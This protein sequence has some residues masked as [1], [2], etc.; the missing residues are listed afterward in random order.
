[1]AQRA[2]AV[3]AFAAALLAALMC[4]LPAT[5][6]TSL[7]SV[8]AT[9]SQAR[10]VP[11]VRGRVVVIGV[12]GLRWS[13]ISATTTPTLW[14]MTTIGS[15]AALSAKTVA[16]NT[17]PIDGWL[18]VSAGQRA[19][20]SHG[21]C[22]LPPAPKTDGARADVPGFAEMREDNTKSKYAAKLGL[23]GDA[24]H[25]A[26]GCTMAV[27]PGATFGAMDGTGLVDS[28]APSIDQVAT[29]G[30][31][32]C[33]LTMVDVDD[34]FR[35]YIDAGVD[36]NGHQV[37]VSNQKRAAA[38]ALADQ[39]IF[40][41]ISRL[42]VGTTVLLAG[43]ADTGSAAHLHVAIATGPTYGSRYL[44]A[45]S[46]HTN[47]LVALT[48]VT[49]TALHV[50]GLSKP[51]DAVGSPWHEGSAKPSTAQAVRHL[52]QEDVAARASS[53]LST[54]YFTALGIAQIGLYVAAWLVLRNPGSPRD[55]R[56][57]RK[58]AAV[59]TFALAVAAVPV[60]TYLAN[61]FPWS[62][63]T[64]PLLAFMGATLAAVIILTGL[65]LAGSWRR[66][67]TVPGAVIGAATAI[68]LTLDVMTGS[69][70]Q[71]D[72]LLG[73]TPLVAG[74]FY[75]FANNAWAVWIMGLIV[76]TGVVTQ[77][78]RRTHGRTVAAGFVVVMGV[79]AM[80]IDAAPMWGADFGGTMAII[81]GFAVFALLVS[82]RKV[83]LKHVVEVLVGGIIF[84]LGLSYADSR[85]AHPTH[86]GDFWNQLVNGNAGTT[87]MRKLGAMIHTFG[88]WNLTFSA[89]AALVFWFVVLM[90]YSPS[91]ERRPIATLHAAYARAPALRATFIAAL[92]TVVAGTLLN[93]SGVSIA[94]MALTVVI[95]LALA[96]TVRALELVPCD[97][98]TPR[99]EQPEAQSASTG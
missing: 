3:A 80:I 56:N 81:P 58:L 88:Y 73:Y 36:V 27:G 39:N 70:L 67:L 50:L 42:P 63:S 11:A 90:G 31:S 75:G 57:R 60:A 12:P 8:S 40:K 9:R 41:V 99:P 13:D 2:A 15:A 46:T 62:K 35:A 86:I 54:P 28:Y 91:R 18:T 22:A 6:T 49:A 10:A 95:P 26:G 52:D 93:D 7:A 16:S 85:R 68:V 5:A 25:R 74:R 55:P 47:G 89:V 1:V 78:L 92:V 66:S 87:V 33:A 71:T 24:V 23:L 97:E 30:W 19:Q 17:C 65:A 98:D 44:S 83:T 20:L 64:H 79:V 37:T 51:D 4:L 76:A 29:G 21:G 53:R 14:Q 59:R 72:D 94:A 34:V 43:L 69:H 77:R 61:L 32:R 84:V 38:A 82:D 48:D 96:A 45:D